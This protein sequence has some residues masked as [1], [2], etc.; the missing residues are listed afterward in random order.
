MT[1]TPEALHDVFAAR[2]SCRAFRPDQVPRAEIE[3]ILNTAC[4]VPSWCNA[5][6]WKIAL[7]SGAETDRFRVALQ[8]EVDSGTPKPDLPF[9]ARYTGVYRERRSETGWQL[10]DAVG[11]K[12]GDRAGSARQMMQNF[13][14]FG[15]PHCAILSTPADLSPYGAIDC[16]SFVTG[17]TIAAQARGVASIAQAAVAS[18]GAFLH[19]YF[20]IPD[21]QL[22]LCA[23]SFGYAD[24]DHPANS[25]RTSRACP[26]T[27][28]DWRG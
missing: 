23:I 16:G 20:D 12:K 24:T 1:M 28:V 26:D 22:I 10:Y 13:A 14:L 25:F 2:H 4:L 9:P 11:V 17:F 19:G 6:P 5:Q 3:Q 27:F 21:D 18:Y 8:K 7:T 15:A